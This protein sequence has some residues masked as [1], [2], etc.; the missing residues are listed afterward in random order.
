MKKITLF[1]AAL[2]L[3][4]AANAQI[5][6]D[7][8][9][10]MCPTLPADFEMIDKADVF[11]E[12]EGHC[13]EASEKA[14]ELVGKTYQN[15]YHLT[16]AQ[17]AQI[18][19]GKKMAE[20]MQ[21]MTQEQQMA[22]A[23]Q[24]AKQRTGGIDVAALAKMSPAQREAAAAK[25]GKQMMANARVN[26]MSIDD[27]QALASVKDP[28]QRANMAKQMGL[29]YTPEEV[30]EM[31]QKVRSSD[32]QLKKVEALI[33]SNSDVNKDLQHIMELDLARDKVIEEG[34]A[35]WKK[36]FNN[37]YEQLVK[38][39]EENG[40]D[41]T[42]NDQG[43][44]ERYMA[45]TAQIENLVKD[46][47]TRYVPLYRANVMEQLDYIRTTAIPHA[48][49]YTNSLK[50]AGHGSVGVPAELE[51]GLFYLDRARQLAYYEDVMEK[52]FEDK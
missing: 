36:E 39:R 2:A 44:N 31:Q 30:A 18:E 34:V 37:R 10:G 20:K 43:V 42:G 3:S 40:W 17:K 14:N 41:D 1:F 12:F 35:L 24:M 4:A 23:M 33:D 13:K 45:L 11:L 48:I 25:L 49:S 15:T 27:M 19:Q 52:I 21:G 6:A 47:Y 7:G 38:A 50:D 32:R 8:I 28:K 46:F 29:T 16:D 5:T 9:L 51:M 22:Y 26:G